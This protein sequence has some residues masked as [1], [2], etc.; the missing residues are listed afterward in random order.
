MAL[1]K[2][3]NCGEQ[4]S[5]KATVC[6]KCGVHFPT[7]KPKKVCKECGQILDI[8]ATVCPECGCPVEVESYQQEPIQKKEVK[9][10]SKKKY[11]IFGIIAVLLICIV[12]GL[13]NKASKRKKLLEQQ[14]VE[15][16]DIKE[17]NKNVTY[18]NKIYSNSL[19]GA[20]DAEEVCVLVV[21]VWHDAIYGNT[22]NDETSKYVIGAS[23][24]NE[25]LNKVYEDDDIKKKLS[26]ISDDQDNLEEYISKLESVP[27]EL[28]KAYDAAIDVNT[29]FKALSDM[30]LSP[31]GSY[32]SYSADENEKVNAF[33][34]AYNTLESVIP[35]KKDVPLY[36]DGKEIKDDLSFVLYVDQMTKRLPESATQELVGF[37]SDK[38]KIC[39]RDGELT[40][41]AISNVVYCVDWKMEDC[42]EDDKKELEDFLTERYGKPAKKEEK[43]IM[44]EDSGKTDDLIVSFTINDNNVAKITWISSF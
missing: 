40:Y 38:G 37:Y 18:L 33:M 6:P 12:G 36:K 21:N 14:N 41:C 20:S 34:T 19:S 26:S 9:K 29:A 42:G 4:I 28:E 35:G 5:D 16:Q 10:S 1:I 7:E 17:Y 24:F 11:L 15:V 23:D 2:C 13:W 27:A 31:T 22:T 30:A 8:D 25:A 43:D 32:N 3:P 39:K 44:W